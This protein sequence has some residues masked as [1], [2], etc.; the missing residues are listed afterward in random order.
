MPDHKPILGLM[1]APGSG[2]SAVAGV[3]AE[4]GGGVIDADALAREAFEQPAV[5]GALREWWG[6]DAFHADGRVDRKR[7]AARVFADEPQRR[8]LEALI[9]P[10]VA[11]GRAVL[12]ERYQGDPAVRFV[13]EDSP[14]LLESGLAESCD[15]LVFVDVPAELRLE[16]VLAT[17]GWGPEEL[18]RREKLQLPL[19]I[20][21]ARAHIVI[22]NAGDRSALR[23]QVCGMLHRVFPD[24][25]P[26]SPASA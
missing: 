13:V 6:G 1:G 18:A 4:L 20:K 26:E 14:L 22:S 17:R 15:L 10:I 25:D 8:R 19:D 24:L 23:N 7:V 5:L 2:K 16:R 11:A 21:R 12:R 9:H 3:L